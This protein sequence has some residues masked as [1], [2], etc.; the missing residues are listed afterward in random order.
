MGYEVQPVS[1][2]AS[3]VVRIVTGHVVSSSS[4]VSRAYLTDSWRGVVVADDD[5]GYW[6]AATLDALAPDEDT[7]VIR[8]EVEGGPPRAYGR[9]SLV[10]IM[11]SW[12]TA[13]DSAE[14][15]E[16][17]IVA[18]PRVT[19]HPGGASIGVVPLERN[20]DFA[21]HIR[22]GSGPVCFRVSTPHSIVDDSADINND[23]VEVETL[24]CSDDGSYWPVRRRA[25]FS[26]I[27]GADFLGQPGALALD[28]A[29]E[30]VDAGSPAFSHGEPSEVLRGIVRPVGAHISMLLPLHLIAETVAHATSGVSGA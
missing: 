11:L 27:S 12:G 9:A 2:P 13:P 17:V 25:W 26:E 19:K 15:S 5:G 20:R 6:L 22:G 7:L 8:G 28:L 21:E 10:K 1:A 14:G 23:S 18:N 24:A 16:E 29:L 4:M 3:S 30:H